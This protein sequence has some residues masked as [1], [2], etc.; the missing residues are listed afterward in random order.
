MSLTAVDQP[1]S[2]SYKAN[3]YG[4]N[5]CDAIP[6]VTLPLPHQD[7]EP[8]INLHGKNRCLSD[9]TPIRLGLI[10]LFVLSNDY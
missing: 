5:M 2:D 7:I 4:F 3:L 6:T 1:Q 10:K 8:I 9:P